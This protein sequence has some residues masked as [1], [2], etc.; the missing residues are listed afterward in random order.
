MFGW[1]VS[2]G[3][4]LRKYDGRGERGGGGWLTWF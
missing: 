3:D 4:D 2:R 1:R